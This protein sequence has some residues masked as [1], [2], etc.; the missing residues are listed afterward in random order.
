MRDGG[1]DGGRNRRDLMSEPKGAIP[2]LILFILGLILGFWLMIPSPI[3]I[4]IMI[5]TDF[6]SGMQSLPN[7]EMAN[8][9]MDQSILGLQILGVL[10]IIADIIV[11]YA[12]FRR[13]EYF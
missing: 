6:K 13:G 10:V 1:E 9:L 7:S 11:I 3:N 8:Q 4:G 2:R 12:L 5:L